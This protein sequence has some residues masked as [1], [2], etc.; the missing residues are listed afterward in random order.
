MC[1]A[2]TYSSP[3]YA[4]RTVLKDYQLTGNMGLMSSTVNE[5]LFVWYTISRI[6]LVDGWGT[7]IGGTGKVLATPKDR[8]VN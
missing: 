3:S 6:R 8:L 1:S 4:T 5:V 2:I 7:S